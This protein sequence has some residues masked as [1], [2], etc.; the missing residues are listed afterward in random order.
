MFDGLGKNLGPDLATLPD[1]KRTTAHILRS[2]IEPSKDI[3]EKFASSIFL[4]DSGKTVTGM[5]LEEND[6][7]V[8]IVIDPL[9]KDQATIINQI[10]IEGRKQSKLSQ[11]PLGM[12][13]KLSR[14]EI[15]DLVAYVM[16]KGD[17][18]HKVFEGGHGHGHTK[19]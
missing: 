7:V 19:Q 9:A 10:E 4:L 2:I 16:S 11:M 3:D 5:V 6:D 15:I 13:D 17:P 12:V 8:K 14:E 18:K 1:E